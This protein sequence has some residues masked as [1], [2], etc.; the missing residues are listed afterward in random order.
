MTNKRISLLVLIA[1]FALVAGSTGVADGAQLILSLEATDMGGGT[2]EVK[3]YAELLGTTY[4]ICGGGFDITTPTSV[5]AAVPA[6]FF[7]AP[8]HTWSNEVLLTPFTT[9][10]PVFG[11]PDADT[12]MDAQGA[13]MN[14]LGNPTPG[15]TTF[16]LTKTLVAT[17]EWELAGASAYLEPQPL[18]WQYWGSRIEVEPGEYVI[19]GVQIGEPPEFLPP[20]ADPDGPYV[21]DISVETQ[22]VLDGSGSH[23]NDEGGFQIVAW[24]WDIGA[25]GSVE[26]AGEKPILTQAQLE[27]LG[28][29]V[30]DLDI[31]IKLTVT[32]NE[33]QTDSRTT[34]VDFIPEP[35]I[36]GLL[37]VGVAGL[38]ARRRRR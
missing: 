9:L 7:G 10:P 38:L 35:G 20:T 25:D 33:A 22:I 2:W 19:E 31:P 16:G 3:L 8:V 21:L 23:D 29:S 37:G 36:V 11:D 24:D 15:N 18:G 28:Y 26:L 12:D 13:G 14:I 5:G 4:G 34:D 30:G 32:D 17:Q 1:A 6:E 27:G